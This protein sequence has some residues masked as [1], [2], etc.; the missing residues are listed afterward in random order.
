MAVAV[1]QVDGLHRRAGAPLEKLSELHG[2]V[3]LVRH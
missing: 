2:N 3:C 1:A